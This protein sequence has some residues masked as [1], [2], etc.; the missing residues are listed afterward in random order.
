MENRRKQAL[1][2]FAMSAPDLATLDWI[3]ASSNTRGGPSPFHSVPSVVAQ[4]LVW[5]ESHRGEL[6][7]AEA[8]A[9]HWRGRSEISATRSRVE[10]ILGRLTGWDRR[11]SATREVAQEQPLEM[12][13]SRDAQ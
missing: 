13:G 6:E 5:L 11:H 4:V 8:R 7:R 9:R 10:R 2:H 1:P 3:S 12:Q